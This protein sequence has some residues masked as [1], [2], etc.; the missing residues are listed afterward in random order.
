MTQQKHLR[1]Q[2]QMAQMAQMTRIRQ[3]ERGVPGYLTGLI[4]YN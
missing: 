1:P 4:Q 2:P 3:E